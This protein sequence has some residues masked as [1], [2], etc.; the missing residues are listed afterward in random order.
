MQGDISN[1]LASIP[2]DVTKLRSMAHNQTHANSFG[3]FV[4]VPHDGNT[5]PI[6]LLQSVYEAP[7]TSQDVSTGL[8]FT[9]AI[10]VL[11]ALIQ[12]YKRYKKSR[13]FTDRELQYLQSL[14]TSYRALEGDEQMKFKE[15]LTDWLRK[16]GHQEPE[17]Q[18]VING[19]AQTSW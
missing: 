4:H 17:V 11:G 1:L 8:S 16:Q 9:L 10:I 2:T 3:A 15:D 6:N 5:N 14:R 12:N 19:L 13:T 18:A 7:C